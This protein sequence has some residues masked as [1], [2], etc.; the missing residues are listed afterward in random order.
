MPREEGYEKRRG[1]S[2]RDTGSF[3]SPLPPSDTPTVGASLGEASLAGGRQRWGDF[4][5]QSVV[6]QGA[7]LA[8]PE[9]LLE[10]L[11]LGT[12]LQKTESEGTFKQDPLVIDIHHKV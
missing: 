2:R 8:S 6:S 3:A 9:S 10:M 11:D 4:H 7:P 12:P 5:T 1:G